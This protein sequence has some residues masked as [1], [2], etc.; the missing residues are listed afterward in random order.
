MQHKCCTVLQMSQVDDHV[1]CLHA[2]SRRLLRSWAQTANRVGMW[3][4]NARN[5]HPDVLAL[6]L[7]F[8]DTWHHTLHWCTAL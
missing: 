3:R 6:D 4:D 8:C 1:S 5:E 7:D 2:V